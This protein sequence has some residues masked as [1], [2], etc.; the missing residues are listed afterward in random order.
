MKNETSITE[1]DR[2]LITDEA[3][4]R[5][6]RLSPWIDPI[7]EWRPGLPR[8]QP[9]WGN[10]SRRGLG[11]PSRSANSLLEDAEHIAS[12]ITEC[13]DP[14]VSFWEGGLDDLTPLC[15]DLFDGVVDALD[16]NVGQQSWLM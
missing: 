7:R 12:G 8:S 11:R 4:I 14:Q 3:K 1:S 10:R 13:R 16:N 9:T 6:N 2:G 15:L 5:G